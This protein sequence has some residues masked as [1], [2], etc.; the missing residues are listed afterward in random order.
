L[1]PLLRDLLQGVGKITAR[2]R[3]REGFAF[4]MAKLNRFFH[5]SAKS[6]KDLLFV[7]AVATAI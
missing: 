6:G 4:F 2:S 3:R 5:D 7:R 1:N